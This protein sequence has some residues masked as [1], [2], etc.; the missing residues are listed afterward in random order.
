MSF[1]RPT[2]RCLT[3]IGGSLLALLGAHTALALVGSSL[4]AHGFSLTESTAGEAL[5]VSEQL[6]TPILPASGYMLD[7]ASGAALIGRYGLTA[8]DVLIALAP[9]LE[10]ATLSVTRVDA[11]G[12]GATV[13][14]AYGLRF[15]ELPI[16]GAELTLHHHKNRLVM[17]RA[18]LPAARLPDAPPS[19]T[20]YLGL[21]DL[22]FANAGAATKVLA[23]SSGFLA[24]AWRFADR[25]PE[26]GPAR[27]L[28]VDA[29]T[30]AVLRE[31]PLTFDLARVF[32][33]NSIAGVL[34]DVELP[35]LPATGYLDGKYFAVYAPTNAEPRAVAP[36]QVF[37]FQPDDP[38]D[39]IFFDQVQAYY[40]ATRALSFFR[41]ELGYTPDDIQIPVR[42]NMLVRGRAD[43]ALYLMPPEG[44]ELLIG[45]GN[46]VLT[47]LA[48]DVDVIAHEFAHHVIFRSVKLPDGESGILHEGTADYFAYAMSG[49]PYLGESIVPGGLYLRTAAQP[50][51][52][53]FD[54]WPV[55]KG[56]H[57]RAQLWS[58]VLWDLRTA[59]GDDADKLVFASLAYLG[60]ASGLRDAFLALLNADRDI[61]PLALDGADA[62]VY[63]AN[64]CLIMNAGVKRGFAAYLDR[65]DG[66]NCGL[67]LVALG[68]ESRALMDGE[69]LQT[70]GKG[71][72]LNLFGKSCSV[73]AASGAAGTFWW[74]LL[75]AA[76]LAPAIWRRRIDHAAIGDAG[77]KAHG[78]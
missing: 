14:E 64:K 24:A 65:L 33:E 16:D 50:D 35:D 2:L 22:G 8:L 62:G 77:G 57:A 9:H 74:L 25:D 5:V 68:A 71:P 29:Q 78:S 38:A 34:T 56:T 49:D 36:D 47:N 23:E 55:T 72:S 6:K 69:E 3:L 61:H 15:G 37:D 43:N 20:D 30:G 63:G 45:M 11:T 51:T 52:E 17:A 58:A 46:D 42:I 40:A 18:N 76:P 7:G 66:L 13:H 1:F 53:R 75:L 54:S 59:L 10:R 41:D 26:G 48:R 70:R 19:D 21:A 32:L 44:P 4:P 73:V 28:V 60:R 31:T 39:R 12:D 67:D 27:E